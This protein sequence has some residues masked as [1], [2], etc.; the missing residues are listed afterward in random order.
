MRNTQ[1]EQNQTSLEYRREQL[2]L[3]DIT[4]AEEDLTLF[5]R[6][7]WGIERDRVIGMINK[8]KAAQLIEVDTSILVD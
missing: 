2:R 1:L 5:A 4:L 6:T 8:L 3:I 7:F